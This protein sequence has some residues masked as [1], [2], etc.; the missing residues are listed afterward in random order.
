[1]IVLVSRAL[2]PEFGGSIG[3][4]YYAGHIVNG[5]AFIIGLHFFIC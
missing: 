4:I 3:I 2:G 1:M 5:A